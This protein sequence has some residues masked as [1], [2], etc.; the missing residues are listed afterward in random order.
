[1]QVT[2]MSRIIHYINTIYPAIGGGSSHRD[3]LI[4]NLPEYEFVVVSNTHSGS[5]TTD[6][7]PKNVLI[8]RFPRHLLINPSNKFF[9]I[10]Y[11][12]YPFRLI[13]DIQTIRSKLN[14]FK[15][16]DF[17]LLHVHGVAFYQD[18]L[19]LNKITGV[20]IYERIVDFSEIK[21][22]LITLHNFFPSYTKDKIT[23]NAYNHYIDMFENIICV[24][25]HIYT[26]VKQYTSSHFKNKNIWFIPNSVDINKFKFTPIKKTNK[27]RIGFIGRLSEERGVDLLVKLM[28]NLPNFVELHIVGAGD[29]DKFQRLHGIIQNDQLH[30]YPNMLNERIP[31]F[32]NDI[33]LLFNPVVVEGIS[34]A[35]LES[36]ASGRPVI[37]L[38]IG[39]RYP[40]INYETGYLINESIDELLDILEYIHTNFEE[41]ILIGCN[42]RQIIENEFS[43][44]KIIPK[45]K[46]VYD[47][48]MGQSGVL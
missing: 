13:K 47:N 44:E 35:T 45:I 23:I 3:N 34:L 31:M 37:M 22:S 1:M 21:P 33:D 6:Q 41:H 38:N 30:F 17:D 27:F 26:Y 46:E 42:A 2:K 25:E 10:R 12:S 8:K 36:M 7:H 28:K 18:L 14:Y 32:L 19:R 16:S 43:N 11:I 20:D 39:N 48:L 29:V 4:R 24:D 15:K 9:N 40:V 5:L